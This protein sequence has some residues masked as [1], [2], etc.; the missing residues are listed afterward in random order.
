MIKLEKKIIPGK[1]SLLV[2]PSWYPPDG[3]HFFREH[4]EA[5]AREGCRVDVL[6]NRLTGL[7]KFRPSDI[8]YL[9]RFAVASGQDIREIRTFTIKIP[10]L[11]RLSIRFWISRYIK[12]FKKYLNEYGRPDLVLAHS[13]IWAG[14]VAMKIRQEYNVPYLLV[15]HRSRFI[16]NT[17]DAR[18]MLKDQDLPLLY[19]SLAGSAQ[20]ITVSGNLKKG[21]ISLFPDLE[22]KILT[23]PNMV[24]TEY[25]NYTGTDK[26]TDPFIFLY[27]GVLEKVK[28]LDILADAFRLLVSE[29]RNVRLRIVGRGS[30]HR[31]LS[32][33]VHRLGIAHAVTLLGYFRRQQLLEEYRHANAFVLP[34]RFEAFGVVLI[35]AMAAGLPVI[36]TRSGGPEDIVPEHCGIIA[37]RENAETLASAMSHVMDHYKDYRADRIREMVVNNYSM[38]VVAGKYIQILS[39]ILHEK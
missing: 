24:N 1:I 17:P 32:R 10:F 38:P 7:S 26:S 23:I 27:A 30:Q 35:E 13:S 22:N 25:F 11:D 21:L 39:D 4:A 2:I 28:G 34:S 19:R 6:I 5:L 9:R 16:L 8:S 29:N 36:T 31:E 12:H 15:E 33:L 37:E 14:A 3:G 20:I 18:A